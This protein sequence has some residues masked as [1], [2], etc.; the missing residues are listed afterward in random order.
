MGRGHRTCGHVWAELGGHRLVGTGEPATGKLN[1]QFSHSGPYCMTAPTVSFCQTVP[2]FQEKE[3]LLF[4]ATEVP[5]TLQKWGWGGG[6]VIARRISPEIHFTF[7]MVTFSLLYKGSSCILTPH[8]DL[9]FS[10]LVKASFLELDYRQ[11]LAPLTRSDCLL[12]T[13]FF[14]TAKRY[15]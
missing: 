11:A 4:C 3:N 7:L 10:K 8:P 1:L 5:P 14:P 6:L 9:L 2:S 12:L 15:F 13:R